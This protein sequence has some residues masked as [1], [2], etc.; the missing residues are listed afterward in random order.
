MI[1]TTALAIAA[2]VAPTLTACSGNNDKKVADS[3]QAESAVV[4][5]VAA[6]RDDE[7]KAGDGNKI[8][9]ASCRERV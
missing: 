7:A 5:M 2:I 1:A 9:R 4:D 3:A 8:G 6:V